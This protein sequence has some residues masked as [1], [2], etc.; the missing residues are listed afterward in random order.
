MKKIKRKRTKANLPPLPPL[1]R[2][3]GAEAMMADLSRIMREQEFASLDDA[4]TFLDRMLAEGGGRFPA[5]QPLSSVE[6]AQALAYQAWEA[7]TE[8]EAVALAREALA[9]SPDC[10]DAYNV[11][12][13]AEGESVEKAC[14]FYRQGVEAGARTLGEEFFVANKGHFWGM[15]ET[16]PYMRARQGLADCLWAMDRTAE[17]IPHSEALLDLNP[18]DNQGIRDVLLSRYLALGND[19]SAERLFRQ[20]PDDWSAAFCWSRVL[21]D[22]RREDQNA[23]TSAMRTAMKCNPHVFDLF[24]GK[25]QLPS[26]LPEAYSPGDRNEAGLYLAAFAQA[27]LTS[28]RAME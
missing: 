10:T 9:I 25:I 3:V 24:A 23:A 28:P 15:I 21:L 19:A 17:S 20:Y 11:L 22:L 13:E 14:D 4:Q 18:N 8:R 5:S 26:E 12:A 16:R 1:P 27:W 2:R 6:Q 7:P